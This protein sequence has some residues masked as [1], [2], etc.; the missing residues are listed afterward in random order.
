MLEFCA[1][2]SGRMPGQLDEDS[3]VALVEAAVLE[4]NTEVGM[5]VK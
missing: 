5:K 1:E 3:L 4:E 2:E